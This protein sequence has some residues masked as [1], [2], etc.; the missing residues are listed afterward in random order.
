M[1]PEPLAWKKRLHLRTKHKKS[2][3][4]TPLGHIDREDPRPSVGEN[5]PPRSTEA[6]TV[7]HRKCIPDIV[8]QAKN[9]RAGKRRA[10]SRKLAESEELSHISRRL[11]S[12]SP[13]Q[14]YRSLL[15]RL[16]GGFALVRLSRTTT[17]QYEETYSYD[18]TSHEDQRHISNAVSDYPWRRSSFYNSS[19]PSSP[20]P[21]DTPPPLPVSPLN[22]PKSQ[23][24]PPP[25][26]ASETW[27]EEKC[28][29]IVQN[30]ETISRGL[31]D[32]ARDMRDAWRRHH[33][34]VKHEKMK[35]SIKVLGLIDP[36][37][38]AGYTKSW[39]MRS[40]RYSQR[41]G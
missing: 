6:S 16:P 35:K 3:L 21:Y 9:L 37:T 38:A 13:P 1:T 4:W 36:T 19:P 41:L 5:V 27:A 39:G 33:R 34:E 14:G 17:S 18:A 30:E 28:N 10:G 40:G 24:A 2:A 15:V 26:Q 32:R 25:S 11:A 20:F 12:D 23:L 8:S 29:S 22:V 7:Q 31:M